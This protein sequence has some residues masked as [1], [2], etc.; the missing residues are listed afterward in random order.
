MSEL[1][2]NKK[3]EQRL[4][5]HMGH[6]NSLIEMLNSNRD[7]KDVF[8]QV[9]ALKG[10]IRGVEE[11]LIEKYINELL[12]EITPSTQKKVQDLLKLLDR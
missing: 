3:I 8:L 4:R 7:F 11:L 6:S 12:I 10:S 5:I 9:T 1:E 2:I